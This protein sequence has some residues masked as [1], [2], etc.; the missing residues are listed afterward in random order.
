MSGFAFIAGCLCG[1]LPE[2]LGRPTLETLEDASDERPQ[3]KPA[4][5]EEPLTPSLWTPGV[6]CWSQG[7]SKSWQI[8]SKSATQIYW[9]WRTS[10][11]P[12]LTFCL[13]PRG[14]LLIQGYFQFIANGD[15]RWLIISKSATQIYWKITQPQF[16][17]SL[18]SRGI[19]LIQGYFQYITNGDI[20][21]R[22]ISRARLKSSGLEE[23]LT[24]SVWTPGVF[25]LVSG[26]FQETLDYRSDRTRTSYLI[27]LNHTGIFFKNLE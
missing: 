10:P 20:R 17:F 1:I 3:H 25:F 14:I 13:N 18:N 21:W 8:L 7:Y 4:G 9:P 19:L 24:L 11:P 5:I 22:I 27:F 26:T 16:T 23:P 15:I 6:F 2:T 12:Q